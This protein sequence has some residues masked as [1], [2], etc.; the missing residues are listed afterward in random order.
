MEV[1]DAQ[2]AGS[3]PPNPY[4]DRQREE[5]E[6]TLKWCGW[7]VLKDLKRATADEIAAAVVAN[8]LRA[9]A[10]SDSVSARRAACWEILSV[11]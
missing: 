2:P 9:A 8:G 4:Q 10:K 5:R 11:R 7:E 6:K 1:D 3:F